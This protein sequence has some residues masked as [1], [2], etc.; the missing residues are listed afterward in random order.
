[1]VGSRRKLKA[2]VRLN[3]IISLSRA[4]SS[5]QVSTFLTGWLKAPP[6]PVPLSLP[7]S[8][9]KS[10][11]DQAQHPTSI[12]QR[13][14]SRPPLVPPSVRPE[15]TSPPDRTT[16]SNSSNRTISRVCRIG[17]RCRPR[18]LRG[19]LQNL[20]QR[21]RLNLHQPSRPYPP[22]FPLSLG[23]PVEQ[24]HWRVRPWR[25]PAGPRKQERLRRQLPTV[26]THPNLLHLPQHKR[27]YPC[28]MVS[29]HLHLLLSQTRQ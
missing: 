22:N 3:A 23:P 2:A 11:A 9:P 7:Q 19:L 28:P 8:C 6:H 26:P 16:R 17:K 18:S 24:A 12:H 1:M 15:T 14:M 20:L 4:D 27:R 29:R 13:Q 21:C 25:P 10:L 5:F